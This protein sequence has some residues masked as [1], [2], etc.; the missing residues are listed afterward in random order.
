LDTL[1]NIWGG[2]RTVIVPEKT[3]N[4][5]VIVLCLLGATTFWFFNALNKSYTTTI[6]YPVNFLFNKSQY[7]AISKLPERI[8]INVTGGG[9]D[10]LRRA[11]WFN[12][13]PIEI[14]LMDPLERGVSANSFRAAIS[15]HLDAFQLNFIVTDSLHFN[16]DKLES[17]KLRLAVDSSHISLSDN[18]FL[19]SPIQQSVD[20]A[21]FQGPASMVEFLPDSFLIKVPETDIDEDYSGNV[22]VQTGS[23]NLFTVTPPSLDISFQ[24]RNF[25]RATQVITAQ[26]VNF[27]KD[28]SWYIPDGNI[29]ISYLVRRDQPQVDTSRFEIFLDLKRMVKQDS[30]IQPIIKSY[31]ENI[32]DIRLESGRIKVAHE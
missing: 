10:L 9:W 31:P 1:K 26:L 32:L 4:W 15:E 5:K 12:I 22:K 2:I 24:V 8:Q 18:Y 23:D 16:I 14:P 27:P 30:T 25:I 6:S 19:V 7:I 28:S 17:K 13:K 20:S 11:N 29:N 21:V 3:T